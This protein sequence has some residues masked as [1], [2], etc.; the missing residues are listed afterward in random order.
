[1]EERM[2]ALHVAAALTIVGASVSNEANAASAPNEPTATE[3][4]RYADLD[5][6]S[7]ADQKRLKDRIS[8]A[9]YR[10]CLVDVPASPTPPIADPVCFRAAI[11]DAREQMDLVVARATGGPALALNPTPTFS[12]HDHK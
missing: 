2:R 4:I 1:M 7:T 11:K 6:R 5:L 12:G 9:A 10:L 3:V 8:F